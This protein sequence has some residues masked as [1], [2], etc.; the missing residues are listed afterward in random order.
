[1]SI[2]ISPSL[3]AADMGHLAQELQ[4]VEE[5]GITSLHIGVMDGNFV[6]NIAFGPDQ[7]KMLRSLSKLKFEVHLMVAYPERYIQAFADAGADL[8]TVHVES[9]IH[10]HKTIQM[11]K[12]AGKRV[13]VAL[14]PATPLEVL[15]YMY[16]LIDMVLIMTINPGYSG[17]KN[18]GDMNIKIKE[19]FDIRQADNYNFKIQV[20]GGIN[21]KNIL[22]VIQA[23]ADSLV[24]GTALF[25]RGKTKQNI[26][27]FKAMINTIL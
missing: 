7:I 23:G 25:Q 3:F 11:I 14:N 18:I 17:E 2:T 19:L 16:D 20:D 15:E 6:P 21:Q 10:L 24:I 8:I 26:E 1:M 13:G 9:C 4:T 12:S 5:S 22:S 27:D